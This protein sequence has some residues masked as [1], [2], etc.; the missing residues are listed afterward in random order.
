MKEGFP[1]QYPYAAATFEQWLREQY[2]VI[3]DPQQ[4]GE[5]FEDEEDYL[6]YRQEIKERGRHFAFSLTIPILSKRE[7]NKPIRLSDGRTWTTNT[8]VH[9]SYFV[10]SDSYDEC[11][12]E[13][14]EALESLG[15]A[16][17]LNALDL[18]I[19]YSQDRIARDKVEFYEGLTQDQDDN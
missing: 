6:A 4:A 5:Y 12:R 1:N 13:F 9:Q 18:E 14:A 7:I 16:G 10:H 3:D 17:R 2:P 8:G 19:H 15:L 11:V